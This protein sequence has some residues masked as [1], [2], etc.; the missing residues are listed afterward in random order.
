[1]RKLVYYVYKVNIYLHD[2]SQNIALIALIKL[3]QQNLFKVCVPC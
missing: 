2:K 1:M 3:E